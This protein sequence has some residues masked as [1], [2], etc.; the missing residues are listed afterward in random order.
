M[1]NDGLSE[2]RT[3]VVERT[4][5][6]YLI[7][8]PKNKERS[9]IIL[10]HRQADP[11]ALCAAGALKKIIEHFE[12]SS[13][14]KTTIVAPQ[15]A[16]VLGK[17]AS[18]ALGIEFE[19]EIEESKIESANLLIAVDTGDP[20]LLEPYN[21]QFEKSNGAK[22]LIDHH[23]S[24]LL[25][26]TWPENIERIVTPHSTSTCEIIALGVGRKS[27]SK[28]VADMLLTGLLFDSQHLGIATK[29]T[30]EAALILVNAGSQISEAKKILRHN[31]ERSEIL[32]KIKA[33]QRL[34]YDEAAGKI[35]ARS[36]ISSF[37]A[38]VARMLVDIGA[39]V[40]IAYGET[41]GEARLSARSSSSFFKQ[42]GIDLSVEITKIANYFELVGGGH[43][44]AAS[45]SGKMDPG[46]LADRLV[47]NLK[48]T[49]LQK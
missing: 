3:D 32:G 16:S 46:V 15:G 49:L 24:S 2:S 44:T 8:E 27:I 37:H 13:L 25:A 21:A 6:S 11:D 47:Q 42:T 39:D 22:I 28:T 18:S 5:Q 23:S 43:V 29:E 45:L 38:A 12:D 19:E 30:L 20:K 31:Q 26:K 40:G 17:Q 9:T 4:I 1:P 14:S 34:R 48:A 33:A 10:V 36:E 35:I 41:G 7:S